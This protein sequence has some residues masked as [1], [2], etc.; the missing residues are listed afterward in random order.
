M[1]KVEKQRRER[2]LHT[3]FQ[4]LGEVLDRQVLILERGAVLVIEPAELL[5]DFCVAGIVSNNAF[6]GIL[7]SHVLCVEREIRTDRRS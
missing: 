1:S 2:E 6:I 4:T 7:G 5:Q 3:C